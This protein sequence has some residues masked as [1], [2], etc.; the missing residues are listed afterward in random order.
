MDTIDEIKRLKA[1]LDQ[2]AITEEEYTSIKMKLISKESCEKGKSLSPN[3]PK[4]NVEHT[5]KKKGSH[6]SPNSKKVSG[7][8]KSREFETGNNTTV[9]LF[10]FALGLSVI[11]GL[12]FWDRYDNFVAFIITTVISTGL[13][14]AV[15]RFLVPKLILRN[16]TLGI[17]SAFLL[18]LIF[19]PIGAVNKSSSS[20]SSSNPSSTSNMNYCST[21]SQYY[22]DK[23]PKCVD[24][25]NAAEVEKVRQKFTKL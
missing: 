22:Y 8:N 20:S 19:V 12:L 4:L 21:H 13:A 5:S 3:E 15:A 18:L 11:L 1:L 2:G 7:R 14:I 23:C 9:R 24:A 6:K 17:L 16:I 10:K 25:R